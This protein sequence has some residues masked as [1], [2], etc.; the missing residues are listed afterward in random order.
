MLHTF[1]GTLILPEKLSNSCDYYVFDNRTMHIAIHNLC[2]VLRSIYVD[3]PKSNMS[4]EIYSKPHKKSEEVEYVC[5]SY[6]GIL[7]LDKLGGNVYDW[8]LENEQDG[9]IFELGNYLFNIVGSYV[10]IKI[11]DTDYSKYR[12]QVDKD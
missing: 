10:H 6:S 8:V 11:L 4:I 12:K 2:D 7:Y 3:S 5:A 1:E 9:S